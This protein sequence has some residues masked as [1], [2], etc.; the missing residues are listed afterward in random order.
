[1]TFQWYEARE[2][3][4]FIDLDLA[5]FGKKE[6]RKKVHAVILT[7]HV[8]M[9]NNSHQET[10]GSCVYAFSLFSPPQSEARNMN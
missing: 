10:N 4:K 7:S 6:K 1:M 3:G 8:V 2:Q 9:I 5:S